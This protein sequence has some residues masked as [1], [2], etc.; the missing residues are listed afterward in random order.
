MQQ[1]KFQWERYYGKKPLWLSIP[2]EAHVQPR[3]STPYQYLTE[4]EHDTKQAKLLSTGALKM[5]YIGQTAEYGT[6]YSYVVD[7]EGPFDFFEHCEFNEK[8]V[9]GPGLIKALHSLR[10]ESIADLNA[11]IR[12]LNI[13]D[14]C[15]LAC[16]KNGLGQVLKSA[17]LSRLRDGT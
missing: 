12:Q 16:S 9:H 14:T 7:N 6:K 13:T 5:K 15:T 8:S 10:E 17:P 3:G 11:Q 1:N 2:E 4:L